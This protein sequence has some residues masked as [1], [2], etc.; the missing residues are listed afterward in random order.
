MYMYYMYCVYNVHLFVGL[1]FQSMLSFHL[2]LSSFYSFNYLFYLFSKLSFQVCEN[3]LERCFNLE[4]LVLLLRFLLD[5]LSFQIHSAEKLK[6]LNNRLLGV[7]ALLCLPHF[8]QEQ[9][10]PLMR[11]PLL[12]VEQ[13]LIDLKVLLLVNI[14]YN[15]HFFCLL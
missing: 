7:K 15:V 8:V 12:I 14:N 3:L 13:L 1:V 9:Y 11:R 5:R 4:S 6:Q 2:C 10:K